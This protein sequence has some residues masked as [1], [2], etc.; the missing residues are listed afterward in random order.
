MRQTFYIISKDKK[1]ALYN[2]IIY[3]LDN[4]GPKT[5]IGGTSES[6]EKGSEKSRKTNVAH[7]RFQVLTA[8]SM[9]FRVY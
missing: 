2:F 5:E 9:K 4:K 7:V 1:I 3:I 8:A 6:T